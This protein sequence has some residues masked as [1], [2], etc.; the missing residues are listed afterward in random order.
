MF[1]TSDCMYKRLV[2]SIINELN[3]FLIESMNIIASL[4]C[5][6]CDMTHAGAGMLLLNKLFDRIQLVF[7]FVFFFDIKE[8][9]FN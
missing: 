6:F 7:V 8:S 2:L 1:N 9:N 5:Y 4:L 3:S